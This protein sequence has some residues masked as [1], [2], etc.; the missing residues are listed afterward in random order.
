[1]SEQQY[2]DFRKLCIK[3]LNEAEVDRVLNMCGEFAEV[4]S[5]NVHNNKSGNKNLCML[6]P[7]FNSES[8]A[9]K[10]K[11]GLTAKGYNAIDFA[12]TKRPEPQ[13]P[14]DASATNIFAD[15]N[16]NNPHGICIRCGENVSFQFSSFI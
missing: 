10:A 9:R 5:H 3:N 12:N 14:P 4:I 16:E 15:F 11:D 6:F 8:D 1:M 2:K 13:S 7:Y